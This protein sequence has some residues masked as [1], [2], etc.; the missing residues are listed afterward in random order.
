M[1]GRDDRRVRP[2][3]PVRAWAH[4]AVAE[5]LRGEQVVADAAGLSSPDRLPSQLDRLV[6]ATIMFW[7]IVL[8]PT[9]SLLALL[10]LVPLPSRPAQ[11]IGTSRLPP[12]RQEGEPLLSRILAKQLLQ[13]FADGPVEQARVRAAQ[14]PTVLR[15]LNQSA[16][17]L[18]S[19]C[20]APACH[21]HDDLLVLT[22]LHKR[23]AS[24]PA[25]NPYRG[26]VEQWARPAAHFLH[27]PTPPSTA[28]AVAHAARRGVGAAL[29]QLAEHVRRALHPLSLIHI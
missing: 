17:P 3:P 14:Q 1:M 27:P 26:V 9:L 15:G 8:V 16:V 24:G 19:L 5:K 10:P 18:L 22:L 11:V 12:V 20:K 29:T 13:R 25:H 21:V 28:A 4:A 6:Q 7:R 23:R 2:R